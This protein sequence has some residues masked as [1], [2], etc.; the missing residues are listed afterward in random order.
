[1]KCVDYHLLFY[2]RPM[3]IYRLLPGSMFARLVFATISTPQSHAEGK[4]LKSLFI[5]V[6]PLL[7]LGPF[8]AEHNLNYPADRSSMAAKITFQACYGKPFTKLPIV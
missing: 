7:K 4:S 5:F 8:D 1:M 3:R 6:S 2:H